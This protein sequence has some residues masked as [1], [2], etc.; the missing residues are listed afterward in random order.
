LRTALREI[1]G[2]AFNFASLGGF[3]TLGRTG[4]VALHSHAPTGYDRRRH[5]YVCM[6]HI[7]IGTDGKLGACERP[8]LPG[9][10]KACG[11]L[12][13][14]HGELM[15]GELDLTL[16]MHDIEQSLLKTRLVKI[17]EWGAKPDLGNMTKVAELAIRSDLEREIA[18]TVDTNEVDYAVF[19]GVQIH[20]PG[21]QNFVWPNV[22]YAVIGGKRHSLNLTGDS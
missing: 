12:I 1:W 11:A 2:E 6:P 9:V 3:L 19:T 16:A 20:A 15:S 17:L 21:G 10:S 8:G 18:A 22:S 5:L 7:G 13:A 14:F 4:F